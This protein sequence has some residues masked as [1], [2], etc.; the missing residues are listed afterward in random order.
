MRLVGLLIATCAAVWPSIA[1]ANPP[2]PYWHP[3]PP[4]APLACKSG[5][6]CEI[7]NLFWVM[8]V[9]SA[10]VFFGVA[11]AIVLSI[12]RFSAREGQP[13][14]TQVFGNR[15][16]ELAWTLIPTLILIVAFIATV[17]A[18]NDINSSSGHSTFAINVVGHQW[19]WEFQYPKQNF[20]TSDELHVPTGQFVQFHV[21]SYDVIH[22]FWSPELQ[23]QIDANPG[24]DNIVYLNTNRPGIYS[25]A[26]YEYCGEAHAWMK[27][28]EVVQTPAQF[29]A[30]IKSQ[31]AL[32]AKP[33]TALQKRGLKVFLSNTCVNCHAINGTT[34]GGAV[35]PNLTHLASR[36]TIGG[37]A[38]PMSEKTLEKWIDDP[39]SY[40]PGVVM[41]GYP[42]LSKQDLHALAAYLIS[43]K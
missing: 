6:M 10:V 40:K 34:A 2:R 9:I 20:V 35:G 26:C 8:L 21:R 7:S 39:N 17:K 22:S 27:F 16:I 25:G 19:W 37:G 18:I 36:W 23:R 43:L 14:P 3:G 5:E 30:W 11:G 29:N 33:K 28:R 24:Q 15:R 38:A 41:P 1:L 12:R 4:W 32:A 42:F 31:Q 13:E